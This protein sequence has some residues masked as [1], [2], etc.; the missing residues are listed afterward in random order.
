MPLISEDRK[1]KSYDVRRI[2]DK[3]REGEVRLLQMKSGV[4]TDDGRLP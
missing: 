3:D 4:E 1:Q 2:S